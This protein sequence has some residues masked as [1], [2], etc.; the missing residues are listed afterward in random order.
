MAAPAG[1]PVP[2]DFDRVH[3]WASWAG[4]LGNQPDCIIQGQTVVQ[5]SLCDIYAGGLEITTRDPDCRVEVRMHG[6]ALASYIELRIRFSPSPAGIRTQAM[7]EA[8]DRDRMSIWYPT[9]MPAD[10]YNPQPPR[11]RITNFQSTTDTNRRTIYNNTY[12]FSTAL[13]DFQF[14]QFEDSPLARKPGVERFPG[15]G[16]Q[17]YFTFKTNGGI[18][19]DKSKLAIHCPWRVQDIVADFRKLMEHTG[20]IELHVRGGKLIATADSFLT[21]VL[22]VEG[23]PM[24][25]A[26]G[27]HFC[28]LPYPPPPSYWPFLAPDNQTAPVVQIIRGQKT[29]YQFQDFVEELFALRPKP[30]F[31]RGPGNAPILRPARQPLQLW[32]GLPVLRQFV[33][34]RQYQAFVLGGYTNEILSQAAN[35]NRWYNG[36][37]ECYVIPQALFHPSEPQ[38]SVL[39]FLNINPHDRDWDDQGPQPDGVLPRAGDKVLVHS[40]QDEKVTWPGIVIPI[41][42][43]LTADAGRANCC[44][45]ATITQTAGF[46]M[47]PVQQRLFLLFGSYGSPT[48]VVRSAINGLMTLDANWGGQTRPLHWLRN[49]VLAQDPKNP[50]YYV[51]NRQLSEAQ[52]TLINTACGLHQLNPG[53]IAV[54]RDVF[55][56]PLTIVHAPPGTGKTH[57]VQCIIDIAT[58]LELKYLAVAP[59]NQAVDVIHTRITNNQY[60]DGHVFRIYTESAEGLYE[61]ED[62]E[63][64]FAPGRTLTITPTTGAG[65]IPPFDTG[66]S[67][68]TA[69]ALRAMLEPQ[70]IVPGPNSLAAHIQNRKNLLNQHGQQFVSQFPSERTRL[71]AVES[72]RRAATQALTQ[73]ARTARRTKQEQRREDLRL[74]QLYASK[75]DGNCATNSSATSRVLMDI[76]PIILIQDEAAQGSEPETLAASIKYA[77]HIQH[78]V[79]LG[80][81]KQLGPTVTEQ[82]NLLREQLKMSHQQ[83]LTEVGCPSHTLTTQYRMHPDISEWSRETNEPLLEDAPGTGLGFSGWD[84]WLERYLTDMGVMRQIQRHSILISPTRTEGV[85]IPFGTAEIGDNRTL[86]NFH[87]AGIIFHLVNHLIQVGNCP[88]KDIMV[89]A[90]YSGQVR[91]LKKFM[92]RYAID[93]KVGTWDSSQGSEAEIVIVDP[94]RIGGQSLGFLTDPGRLNVVMTR[95]KTGRIVIADKNLVK[96]KYQHTGHRHWSQLL[97]KHVQQGWSFDYSTGMLNRTYRQSPLVTTQLNE[98]VRMANDFSAGR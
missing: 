82:E 65:G 86:Y 27:L 6:G 70:S 69:D 2:V 84:L 88:A 53:Q 51:W 91:L 35:R 24:V 94:V 22:T 68:T 31:R 3:P 28:G 14:Q 42:N 60:Q 7:M 4:L 98:I 25:G 26:Y 79:I 74:R 34:T 44:I 39:I 75:A 46:V 71:D 38:R 21:Y 20:Q 76:R 10:V 37:H 56:R 72:S 85:N 55:T 29:S 30:I 23:M 78:R 19:I 95:A 87:S 89:L 93:V 61:D 73:D 58:Q 67:A 52:K 81:E 50:D 32:M 49:I 64:E 11:A 96:G 57:L 36:N 1:Q 15:P 77:R 33:S 9:F 66:V 54:V 18:A 83:R 43:D 62:T 13:Y 80:D 12:S 97:D 59:S 48:R 90:A 47:A 16:Q 5:S 45:R 17:H 63:I 40:P 8:D 92:D 41:P